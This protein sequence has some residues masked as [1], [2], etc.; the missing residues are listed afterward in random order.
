MSLMARISFGLYQ[1]PQRGCCFRRAMPRRSVRSCFDKTESNRTHASENEIIQQVCKL[2]R[3]PVEKRNPK[4][5]AEEA[6]RKL[7]K[8]VRR[9]RI[10]QKLQ[11]IFQQRGLQWFRGFEEIVESSNRGNK[12]RRSVNQHTNAKKI[13]ALREGQED[14][15]DGQ[16]SA[17]A[18]SEP[19]SGTALVLRGSGNQ[20]TKRRKAKRITALREGQEDT[21]DGLDFAAEGS[22]PVSGTAL[23]MQLSAPPGESSTWC[24][25]GLNIQWPFSQLL[26]VGIKTQEVRKYDL[27]ERGICYKDTAMWLVETPGDSSRANKNAISFDA[28]IAARPTRAQ[29]VGI[30]TFDWASK[31]VTRKSFC[32]ARGQHCISSDSKFEWDG[33]KRLYGW[34]VKSV[35]A[36]QTPVPIDATGQIGIGYKSCSVV[37]SEPGQSAPGHSLADLSDR[38]PQAA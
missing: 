9:R 11:I 29:I 28:P 3:L 6:E 14:T 30:I 2:G 10:Q 1:G 8:Q 19:V 20:C 24:L 7:A 33:R 36:L 25:R 23:P 32:D 4:T 18:G 16:E 26:L 21:I 37:I 15:T 17:A 12:G 38:S 22:E 34:H 31:Y 13:A 27:G 35:H 5:P